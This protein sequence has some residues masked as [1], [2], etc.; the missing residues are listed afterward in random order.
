MHQVRERSIDVRED[1]LME[2]PYGIDQD[3]ES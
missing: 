2:Q 3:R 1:M